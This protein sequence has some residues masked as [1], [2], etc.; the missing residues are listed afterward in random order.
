MASVHGFDILASQP[1]PTSGTL[2]L[3]GHNRD[4]WTRDASALDFPDWHDLD[5]WAAFC[6]RSKQLVRMHLPVTISSA[7][8]SFFSPV[9]EP[10]L[11]IENLPVDFKLPPIPSDGKR[12]SSK[13]AVSEAVI[14]GLVSEWGEVMSYINEKQGAPIHEVA[15]VPGMERL[16]SNSGR[17]RFGF[18]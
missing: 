12:P 11:V 13:Q 3:P 10:Y 17:V 16:Q 4:A 8:R 5:A 14:A 1:P 18:H 2:Q 7:L 9:G 6:E 15:P